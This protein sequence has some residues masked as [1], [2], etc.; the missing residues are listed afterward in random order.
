VLRLE[1]QHHPSGVVITAVAAVAGATIDEA[2]GLP[3]GQGRAKP[4]LIEQLVPCR[5]PRFLEPCVQALEAGGG[6]EIE[7]GE[8]VVEVERADGDRLEP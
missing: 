5:L 2:P 3:P 8:Q 1:V 4:D 7:P 6:C